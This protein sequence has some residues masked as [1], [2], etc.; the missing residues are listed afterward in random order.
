MN[1]NFLFR[2]AA[3]GGALFWLLLLNGC[4]APSPSVQGSSAFWGAVTPYKVEIVQGNVV[5]REQAAQIKTGMPREQ[6][7]QILGSPLLTDVFHQQRWD[8]LF[9]IRRQGLAAKQLGMTVFFDA[10]DRVERFTD[11][12]GLPSEEEFIASI[13][14]KTTSGKPP[15]LALTP[16]Q[17]AQLP[18][19]PSEPDAASVSK[20]PASPRVYPRLEP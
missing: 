16:E 13:A 10:Q 8:Y 7:R 14:A 17:I 5:T 3:G 1:L 2:H 4:S 18:L 6:V 19:P 15:V 12:D 9:S 20:T 11:A